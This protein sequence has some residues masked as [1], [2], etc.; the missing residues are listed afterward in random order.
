MQAAR[1]HHQNVLSAL[2]FYDIMEP[3]YCS[4]I[5]EPYAQSG[6]STFIFETGFRHTEKKKRNIVK[7]PPPPI[8]TSMR[9][10]EGLWNFSK[11]KYVNCCGDKWRLL[12]QCET[13]SPAW[14]FLPCKT[15]LLCRATGNPPVT[16]SRAS[17]VTSHE[18][19]GS[20]TSSFQNQNVAL[21]QLNIA[22]HGAAGRDE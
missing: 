12:S 5:P 11:H 9:S 17:P 14:K 3:I 19:H 1:Q 21:N 10:P 8:Y 6:C 15:A 2:F 13:F 22:A 4:P 20:L 18:T 7:P 16:W